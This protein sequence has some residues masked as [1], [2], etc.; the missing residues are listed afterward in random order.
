MGSPYYS[1]RHT[2]STQQ[3][4]GITQGIKLLHTDLIYNAV[5]YLHFNLIGSAD[6][7]IQ[8]ET[9]YFHKGQ[10]NMYA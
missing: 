2:V 6:Y 5:M 7:Q 1:A 9:F 3:T 10:W 8:I 4:V